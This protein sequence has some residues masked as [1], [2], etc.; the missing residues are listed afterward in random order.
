LD[1]IVRSK[2]NRESNNTDTNTEIKNL[3]D[4]AADEYARLGLNVNETI[5]QS[6]IDSLEKD[7]IWFETETINGNLYVVPK[8]YLTKATR[9]AL[10]DNDSL[11]T[12]STMFAG[13]DLVMNSTGGTIKNGGSLNAKNNI[14]LNANNNIINDNFS[15]INAEG[16]LSLVSSAGSIIN[17]SSLNA[18]G[19]LLL[20]AANN[21]YNIATVATN[22]TNLLGESFGVD[23]QGNNISPYMQNSAD[24]RSS[25]NIGSKLIETANI[26]AGSLIVSAGN[27]FNN[28]GSNINSTGDISITA[29]NDVNVST[30]ELRNRSEFRSKNYTSI[31]DET[32]NI[33]SNINTGGNFVL[34][35]NNDAFIKGSNINVDGS[36]TI[37]TTGDLSIVSATDSYY[38]FEES[39]KKGS[40]GRRSS[41][42]STKSSTTNVESNINVAGDINSNS[43]KNINIIASNLTSGGNINLAAASAINIVAGQDTNYTKTTSNKKGTTIIK[44]STDI[45]Y[46]ITNIHSDLNATGNIALT[47][48]TNT[49][50]VGTNI[51]L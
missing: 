24:S 26:S 23:D 27:N 30:V 9:Q 42:S 11:A 3:L 29:G 32:K 8:I 13:A 47:S 43:Q 51:R 34:N 7:I 31:T 15:D 39:S 44:N 1:Y 6:Q 21:V 5:T 38:K 19:S 4:N 14:S 40:F 37:N 33:G 35:A 22:D 16:N 12:K 28:I 25:G 17:K 20:S 46:D 50:L 2:I 36:A 48:G 41:S 10:K 45:A 49:N 18:G